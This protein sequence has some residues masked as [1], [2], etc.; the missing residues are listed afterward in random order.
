MDHSPPP[1]FLDRVRG[2]IRLKHYSLR[3][4]QA[5]VDW[6]KRFILFHGKR[7]PESMAAAEVESF[8]THLAVKQHVAASTQNQ[9]KSALLFMYKHVLGVE[10]P[11]L[12]GVEQA[13]TPV[14]LP[15]VM[16]RDE[17]ARVLERLN[18]THLLIG[19]LLYGTGMRIMEALRLRVKD[20]E[21]ARHGGRTRHRV[22]AN[23]AGAQVPDRCAGVGLAICLSGAAALTRSARRRRASA[24][25]IRPGLP[26]RDAAGRPR[27]RVVQAGNAAHASFATHLLESGYDARTVQELLGHADVS[28]TMLYTHVLNRGGRGVISPLD[29]L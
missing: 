6:I 19:Q 1:R 14:R 26:A 5:Y 17:V 11:W 15:V 20:V 12:D 7:R 28:T 2:C 23:R 13:K 27:R 4:E 9:A 18:G 22:A 8:L 3:T 29:R 25:R 21:F 10:L 24:S 16:T